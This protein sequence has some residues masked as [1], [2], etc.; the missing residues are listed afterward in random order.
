VYVSIYTYSHEHNNITVSSNIY[1]I[2]T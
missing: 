1:C 2:V